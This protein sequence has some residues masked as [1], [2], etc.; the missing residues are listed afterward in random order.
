M[1]KKSEE[2]PT[3][4]ILNPHFQEVINGT[5]DSAETGEIEETGD[6]QNKIEEE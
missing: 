2:I 4:T 1:K 3:F 5:D 6:F